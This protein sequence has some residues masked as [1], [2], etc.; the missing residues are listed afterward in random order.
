MTTLPEAKL[1]R[2]AEMGYAAICMSTDYDSWHATNETVSVDMVMGHMKA[3]AENAGR[4]ATAVLDVLG[5]DEE[6]IGK[7]REGKQWEGQTKMAAGITKEEGRSKEA[8]SRL[9]WLFPDQ[10]GALESGAAE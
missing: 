10:F 4:V 8:V 7:V 9:A 2:E 1:A 5:S 3:N 6:E